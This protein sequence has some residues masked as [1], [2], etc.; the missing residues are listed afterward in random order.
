MDETSA[1]FSELRNEAD[2]SPAGYRNGVPITEPQLAW[3]SWVLG[4]AL[5]RSSVLAAAPGMVG[6]GLQGQM[7]SRPCPLL[8][9]ST[10]SKAASPANPRPLSAPFP[11]QTAAPLTHPLAL[12]G[13]SVPHPPPSPLERKQ[14]TFSFKRWFTPPRV[15]K[16]TFLP[17]VG[18][19]PKLAKT[20][21][22]QIPRPGS[23]S[24]H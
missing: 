4:W 1:S 19:N 17:E 24:L 18:N 8:E 16:T 6:A 7:G 10:Q 2:T 21:E 11:R 9:A 20:W 14:A 15:T 13:A 23:G 12:Q 3:L 5:A 22:K